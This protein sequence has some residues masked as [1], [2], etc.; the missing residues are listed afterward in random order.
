[1]LS[2]TVNKN[3]IIITVL[4]I[5]YEENSKGENPHCQLSNL[6]P[7]PTA[8]LKPGSKP[9]NLKAKGQFIPVAATL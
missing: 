2:I 5:Q 7:G 1:L 9:G 4:Y 6:F 8:N 3:K